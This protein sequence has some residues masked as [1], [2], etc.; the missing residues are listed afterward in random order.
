M[1]H[2]ITALVVISLLIAIPAASE[3]DIAESNAVLLH[4]FDGGKLSINRPNRSWLVD[5][6]TTTPPVIF[7]MISADSVA[8]ANVQKIDVPGITLKMLKPMILSRLASQV[9]D[10]EKISERA[11]DVE[12][13]H[14]FEITC[15]GIIDDISYK[16]IYL[17]MKPSDL[18][19]VVKCS[20][21]EDKFEVFETDFQ[22][23][24]GSVSIL[25]RSSE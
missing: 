24:I 14:A 20:A 6:D 22:S 18:A 21:P 17:V 4:L 13:F 23:I 10:F 15:T 9:K 3:S 5:R 8:K 16:N 12:G 2:Q 25:I 11:F 7:K 1:V 19:Y